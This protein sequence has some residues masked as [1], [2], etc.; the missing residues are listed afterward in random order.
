MADLVELLSAKQAITDVLYRYCYAVDRRDPE[1][2]A[3][4]WHPGGLA[5]YGNDIFDGTAEDYIEQVF[6][7]HA[8]TDVTSHQLTNVAITVDG[9]RATSESYVTA[10]I[11]VGTKDIVVRGRYADT[12]SRRAGEWRIDERWFH[13]DLTQIIPVDETPLF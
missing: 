12:W 9:D 11:R 3:Q 1:L 2:G 6:E 7:Q 4:I 10:S 13:H 8:L 5:H